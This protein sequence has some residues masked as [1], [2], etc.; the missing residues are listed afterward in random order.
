VSGPLIDRIDIHVE[1]PPVT[2][3]ELRTDGAGPGM[4]SREMRSSVLRAR[5]LQRTRFGSRDRVTCNANM[6]HRQLREF[7]RL[8]SA[9]EALLKQAMTELG[10]SAR[11]HD[12]V[13]RTARTIADVEENNDIQAHHIAEAIQ[14]RRLD[15]HI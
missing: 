12:K 5:A 1:V 10:L 4:T 6:S 13:M 9:G 14:Y 3:K 15:R 2:W 7:C 8:D 11:A